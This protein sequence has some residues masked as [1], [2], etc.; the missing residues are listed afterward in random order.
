MRRLLTLLILA[1]PSFATPAFADDVTYS[2]RPLGLVVASPTVVLS[3]KLGQLYGADP[4]FDETIRSPDEPEG[5]ATVHCAETY[6]I[7]AVLWIR[8]SNPEL[9]NPRSTHL[10]NVWTHSEHDIKARHLDDVDLVRFERRQTSKVFV[11]HLTLSGK[12][13][14]DGVWTLR[15]YMDEELVAEESFN[16]IDCAG[17][18]AEIDIDELPDPEVLAAVKRAAEAEEEKKNEPVDE[19]E[20]IIVCREEK[21]TGSHMKSTVC[22]TRSQIDGRMERDQQLVRDIQSTPVQRSQ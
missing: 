14:Q 20:E 2:V 9:I 13:K 1:V 7:G 22:Y 10:R 12:I 6:Q 5:G 21:R 11:V 16:L 15:S 17:H 19:P 18:F 8:R 4:I 3:S